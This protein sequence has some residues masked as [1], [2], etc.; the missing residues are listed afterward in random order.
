VEG[1]GLNNA[2]SFKYITNVYYEIEDKPME[3]VDG[4]YVG[5]SSLVSD[6]K[7][8][9][10]GYS[11]YRNHVG[12]IDAIKKACSILSERLS[13]ILAEWEK[14]KSGDPSDKIQVNKVAESYIIT[15]EDETYTLANL[16]YYYVFQEMPS[17][18]F[19]SGGIRHMDK[20]GAVVIIKNGEYMKL[21]SNGVSA[22][23][24]D[25]QKVHSA[26]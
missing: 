14:I 3:R 23:I 8:F 17:I 26:F 5:K 18:E 4:K 20:T 24:K 22:A 13:G 16:I 6:Y 15:I 11:T 7:N 12:A 25:L 9:T 19:A 1:L 21:F 10:I 2:N